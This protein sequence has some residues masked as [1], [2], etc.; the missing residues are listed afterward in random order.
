[1]VATYQPA[2]SAASNQNAVKSF[3]AIDEKQKRKL[4]RTIY[5]E[6]QWTLWQPFYF[7]TS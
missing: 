4:S 7:E 5:G 1:M 6:F 2:V 3:E